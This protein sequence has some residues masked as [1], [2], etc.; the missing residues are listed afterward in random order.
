[1]SDERER[2]LDL[3]AAVS[4][5]RVV[6]WPGELEHARTRGDD[7]VVA[8]L[9]L[10]SRIASVHGSLA[11]EEIA[12]VA[13]VSSEPGRPVGRASRAAGGSPP[14]WGPLEIIEKIGEGGFGD[15]HRAWDPG[16]G[17]EVALKL[18]RPAGSWAGD[19]ANVFLQEGR[20]LAR[21][22]H[23][24]VATV[25]GAE[26]HE[27]RPGLWMEFIRGRTL[28]EV[29]REQGPFGA[30][31]AAGVGLDLCRALAAVHAAGLV[32]RD[33]KAQNVMRE[34]GG[35]IVLMD[36][37]AG[38]DV[39]IESHEP[40]SEVSGTPLYMA[41]ETLRGEVATFQ[42]DIYSLGVLL[43]H[44]VT[45]AYPV[46]GATFAELV[47]R[48]ARKQ[49]L[50]LRDVRPDIPELFARAVER[51]LSWDAMD[52]PAT[53]GQL[54]QALSLA[55]G[56]EGVA[57]G[58]AGRA[59]SPKS[60]SRRLGWGIG[61]TIAACLIA[62]AAWG[63][64]RQWRQFD[65]SHQA[66]S[67]PP[68]GF[69]PPL[70]HTPQTTNLTPSPIERPLRVEARFYRWGPLYSQPLSNGDEI[71]LHDRLYLEVQ[72]EEPI[73]VYVLNQDREGRAY[74]IF[75]VPDAKVKNPLSA[76]V[77]HSLPGTQWEVDSAGEQEDFLV[78]ASRQPLEDLERD[79]AGVPRATLEGHQ[80]VDEGMVAA[81]RGLGTVARKRTTD[82]HRFPNSPAGEAVKRLMGRAE[83]GGIWIR[84]FVLQNKGA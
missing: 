29:L 34:E 32:H 57:F 64:V 62:G 27:G 56:A 39:R 36:F 6:D 4:D 80:E 28:E 72:G 52:R 31:E 79:L 26:E 14:R 21:V 74:V 37:G 63:V 44:L 9:Q 11:R 45:G 10:V 48:H 22:R 42:S 18:L 51:A 38:R 8:S 61:G 54:E 3:A 33:I 68:A 77:R 70:S 2:I 49:R 40:G 53:P 25:H 84:E 58:D 55:V 1:M 73:Y 30:R 66:P 75:P 43:F 82:D 78:I 47:Q 81:L 7:Q 69:V 5:G 35:R 65:A 17:R 67:L 76:G 60:V 24:H 23:A 19:S 16:L 83:S 15:V 71:H 41:P 20:M 59:V 13:T 46:S 50:L 12:P